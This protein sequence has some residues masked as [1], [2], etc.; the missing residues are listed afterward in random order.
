MD[1]NT[2]NKEKQDMIIGFFKFKKGDKK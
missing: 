2:T 1:I